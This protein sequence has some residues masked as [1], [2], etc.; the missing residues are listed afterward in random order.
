MGACLLLI[1]DTVHVCSAI[2]R[3]MLGFELMLNVE[4]RSEW[5]LQWIPPH[6]I[7]ADGIKGDMNRE[8]QPGQTRTVSF[9]NT[10]QRQP[11]KCSLVF[12]FLAFPQGLVVISHPIFVCHLIAVYFNSLV[13]NRSS[14]T[15]HAE[16]ICLRADIQ[17]AHFAQGHFQGFDVIK[18]THCQSQRLVPAIWSGDWRGR[19][20]QQKRA[21]TCSI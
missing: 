1:C 12:K 2:D 9:S 7:Y 10:K 3:E 16:D 5:P 18:L 8:I 17:S 20:C 14:C 4:N 19:R 6:E 15:V 13:R 11:I 21:Q